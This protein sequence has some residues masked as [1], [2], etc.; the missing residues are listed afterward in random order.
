ME[1]KQILCIVLS[2]IV[3]LPLWWKTVPYVYRFFMKHHFLG[4]KDVMTRSRAALDLDRFL[5]AVVAA[6]IYMGITAVFVFVGFAGLILEI[7]GR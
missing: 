5:G 4:F 2:A 7:V 6:V 3:L 1:F